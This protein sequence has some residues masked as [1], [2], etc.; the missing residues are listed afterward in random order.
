MPYFP[1]G[2]VRSGGRGGGGGGATASQELGEAWPLVVSLRLHR[3]SL[4]H[5]EERVERRKTNASMC[6]ATLLGI[7]ERCDG[8]L[9]ENRTWR[10]HGEV[11]EKETCQ[12]PD[13]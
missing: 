1:R 5:H 12:H 6:G 8:G 11:P 9:V 13:F 3:G 2:L 4:Q 10:R 7:V